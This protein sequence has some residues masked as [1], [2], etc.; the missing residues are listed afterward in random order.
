MPDAVK[1]TDVT[2]PSASEHAVDMAQPV[3]RSRKSLSLD[4]LRAADDDDRQQS[5]SF[6]YARNVNQSFRVAVDKSYDGPSLTASM[7]G[8]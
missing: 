6:M 5:Q 7:A 4:N 1:S 8:V 3:R 2:S